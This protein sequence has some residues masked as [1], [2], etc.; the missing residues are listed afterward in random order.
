MP[1]LHLVKYSPLSS[2]GAWGAVNA[3]KKCS[4]AMQL[5]WVRSK[6]QR[7]VCENTRMKRIL[8]VKTTSMGDVI[9]ALPVVQD[10][11]AAYPNA[12]IDWVVEEG[13]ADVPR[14][15]P[16]VHQ[17]WT[18]AVRRWRK[19][20][21]RAQTWREIATVKQ[22]LSTQGYDVVIDLQGLIK[23]ALIARWARGALHG[24]DAQSIREPLASRCY[25]YTY[26]IPYR[27][28][29][30]QRMRRLAA[31]AMGYAEPHTPPDY[32]LVFAPASGKI[33]AFAALHATSRD[34]KLW[35]ETHWVA[36]GQYYAE[37]GIHM[38]LPWATEAEHLRAQRIAQQVPQARVLPRL[39]LQALALQ[40]PQLQFA[41]GVDTGLSHFATALGLPVVAL[42][43]D[44]QPQ[45]TGV[46]ASQLAPALNLGG[47]QQCPSVE[48]VI[49][50]LQRIASIA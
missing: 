49:A 40:L 38:W 3:I 5:C 8:L 18:V 50:S 13:F 35:P 26:R 19:A 6:W 20:W 30:V 27:Q 17:V 47:Q 43:T 34:S 39:S 16:K 9:H 23:S 24:Y 45:L 11:L 46:Q 41:V 4:V 1:A 14:L 21:W 29:A 22:A 31:L 2:L 42:Y 7:I 15:H 28:H 36:L 33:S 37:R 32:G 44:S 48:T 12:C 10:I 25:R